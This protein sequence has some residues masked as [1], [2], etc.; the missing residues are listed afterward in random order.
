[1]AQEQESGT[2]GWPANPPN[3]HRCPTAVFFSARPGWHVW[4]LSKYCGQWFRR[5]GERCRLGEQ[6]RDRWHI[7]CQ[8]RTGHGQ[9][10]HRPREHGPCDGRPDPSGKRQ[11]RRHGLG[12]H[13]SATAVHSG[14]GLHLSTALGQCSIGGSAGVG[15]SASR[16][17]V[18]WQRSRFDHYFWRQHRCCRQC[19]RQ[20]LRGARCRQVLLH[21]RHHHERFRRHGFRRLCLLPARSCRSGYNDFQKKRPRP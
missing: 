10:H 21:C 1:M 7:D 5:C 12:A 15:H 16:W 4:Q 19:E 2:A 11:Y 9:F 20:W 13:R 17:P 18:R 8:R 3:P 14:R 6:W